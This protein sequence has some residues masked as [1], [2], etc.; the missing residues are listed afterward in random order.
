MGDKN[1]HGV[2][3]D[4]DIY[5]LLLQPAQEILKMQGGPKDGAHYVKV[6]VSGAIYHAHQG[7]HIYWQVAH[8]T[9]Q[10]QQ[11]FRFDGHWAQPCGA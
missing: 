1:T 2:G 3:F 8:T 5:T 6:A 9:D 11:G 4:N 10:P 7:L